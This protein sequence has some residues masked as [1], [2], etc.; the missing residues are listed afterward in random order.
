MRKV[1]ATFLKFYQYLISPLYPQCCR[2]V[3]SC[4][5]YARQAILSHGVIHGIV[6][7][8]RRLLRCHPLCS[9]G[10]DPVPPLNIAKKE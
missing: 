9:G 3:P 4:S 6:L 10:Y 8:V 1:L 7:T 2:F 5:E